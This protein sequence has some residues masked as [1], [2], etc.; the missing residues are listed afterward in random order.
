VGPLVV[1]VHM[2]SVWVP[3]TSESKEAIADYDEIARE[4]QLAL[5]ECGR[6]VSGYLRKR[7]KQRQEGQKRSVFIRYIH[8][9]VEAIGS[10]KEIDKETFRDDLLKI[11]QGHTQMADVQLDDEGRP[12]AP[13]EPNVEPTENG[14]IDDTTI[15]VAQ[16]QAEMR[17]AEDPDLLD[18]A[19]AAA[20][21]DKGKGGPK[22][23][24]S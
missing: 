11:A 19:E 7:K 1:M 16:N 12:I 20:G 17:A 15:V 18:L 9:V 21:G 24:A 8:E 5:Q 3:F 14:I 22:R 4:I 13:E 6:K 2:A 10:I 23:K